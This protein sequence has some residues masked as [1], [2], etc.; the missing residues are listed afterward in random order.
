[1]K[2]RRIATGSAQ[3]LYKFAKLLDEPKLNS[4]LC[5]IFNGIASMVAIIFL[6]YFVMARANWLLWL[7]IGGCVCM[8]LANTTDLF[9]FWINSIAKKIESSRK[10]N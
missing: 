7:G 2:N 1:M 8:M 9:P 4:S 3:I 10:S 5:L 6:V